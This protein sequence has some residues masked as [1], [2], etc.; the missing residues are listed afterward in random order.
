MICIVFYH[1]IKFYFESVKKFNILN[2]M[3]KKLTTNAV[4][5][6]KPVFS[7]AD[8]I[9]FL[10]MYPKSAFPKLPPFCILCFL[11]I[12]CTHIRK[13]YKPE[14]I[15]SIHRS[16]PFYCFT[17]GTVPMSFQMSGIG[18]PVSVMHLEETFALGAET[19]LFIGTAGVLD[20]TIPYG[21][22]L[23]P[24]E[25]V[26]DE[27]TSYHYLEPGENAVPDI[28]LIQTIVDFLNRNGIPNFIG[29]TWTTDAPFRETPSR[30]RNRIREG[31]ISVDMESSALFAVAKHH[32][33]R[34]AGILLATDVVTCE[35]WIPRK[36][37][38]NINAFNP[39]Q[40]LELAVKIGHLI[41]EKMNA[42]E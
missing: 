28:L 21:S 14:V 9:R 39:I 5:K 17:D 11:P 1:L 3:K 12:L 13:K 33:R 25:A 40:L 42:T 38:A 26:R 20:A 22:V 4:I 35:K 23:I 29:K 2:W 19:V 15:N 8:L 31:C 6:E 32:S 36:S 10:G 37:S 24:T 16:K 34:I 18:A 27:G 7:A 30:I 41:Q